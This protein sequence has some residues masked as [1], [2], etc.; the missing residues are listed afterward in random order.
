[1]KDRCYRQKCKDYPDY[2][3]RGISIC[4]EWRD[5]FESFMNWAIAN[6]YSDDLTIDRKNVNGDYEPSNCRW[7]SNSAQQENKRN[8]RYLDY[9]GERKTIKQ[10]SA[11]TGIKAKTIKARLDVYGWSIERALTEPVAENLRSKREG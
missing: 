3:G 5:S 9:N 11:S 2:G 10:W 8:T 1:M 4:P 6:G 7:V